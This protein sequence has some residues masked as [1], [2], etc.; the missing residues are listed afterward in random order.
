M[1]LVINPT[2]FMELYALYRYNQPCNNYKQNIKRYIPPVKQNQKKRDIRCGGIIINKN[3]D[4]VIIVLNRD[5][6]MKGEDKWGLPKGHIKQ[7]EELSQCAEREIEEETGLKIT[8]N[9]KNPRIKI[10]DTYYYI[11]VMNE[12]ISLVPKDKREIAEVKWE[13]IE[14]MNQIN[15]NRGLRKLDSVYPKIIKLARKKMNDNTR[16]SI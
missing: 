16:S 8:I 1:T 11:I 6:K 10:N 12:D 7:G 14:N 2:N 5:S 9:E 4:S 15:T 3:L 13:R